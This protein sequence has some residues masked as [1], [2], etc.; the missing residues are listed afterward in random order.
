MD[1]SIRG[2]QRR[3]GDYKLLNAVK[4]VKVAVH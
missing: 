1:F 2:F 4:Y 3:K